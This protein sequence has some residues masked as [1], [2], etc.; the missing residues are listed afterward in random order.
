MKLPPR[1]KIRLFGDSELC[2]LIYYRHFEALERDFLIRFLRPGDTFVDVGANIGLF[3]LIAARCV[4][5]GG[6]VFAFEP[7]AMTYDRL[8]DNVRLNGLANVDC[9]K[10]AL[11]DGCGRLQLMRASGGFDG[12]NSLARPVMGEASEAEEVEVIRW[13]QYAKQHDLA[14]SVTMMKI[15]V[16]G[17]ESRVLAGG[18]EVLMRPDA[19][20]LQVEFT[21]DA[22]EAAGT[23]CRELYQRLEAYGYRM[24]RYDPGRHALT[25]ET[26]QERYPYVNLIAAKDADFVNARIR[27]ASRS[28]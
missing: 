27:T 17:W 8:T 11:S 18:E 12:W 16:E 28:S 6:R 2:R 23:S 1:L 14:G 7:T 5:P 20:V 3:S 19:P 9:I 26:R 21:D 22:A 15:D 25:P 10:R 4:E 13:D 24:F